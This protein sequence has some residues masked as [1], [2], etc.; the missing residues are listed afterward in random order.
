MPTQQQSSAYG[1][2]VDFIART[3]PQRVLSF[4]LSPKTSQHV[5]N[6]IDREKNNRISKV[7][8]D[9]LDTYMHLSRIIMLAQTHANQILHATSSAKNT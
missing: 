6:L 8:R 5:E 1:E 9:E 4:R 7:E 3:D 2:L